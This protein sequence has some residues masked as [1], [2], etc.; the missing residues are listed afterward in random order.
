[1]RIQQLAPRTSSGNVQAQTANYAFDNMSFIRTND[2]NYLHMSCAHTLSAWE[3]TKPA[4]CASEGVVTRYCTTCAVYDEGGNRTG[5]YSETEYLPALGH[6]LATNWT[7]VEDT[8][9]EQRVCTRGGCDYAVT[10]DVLTDGAVRFDDGTLVSNS[11]VSI[12]GLKTKDEGG[13]EVDVPVGATDSVVGNDFVQYAIVDAPGREGELALKV[14]AVVANKKTPYNSS[15]FVVSTTDGERGNKYTLDFDLYAITRDATN[16]GRTFFHLTIG[17]QNYQVVMYKSAGIVEIRIY[18]SKLDGTSGSVTYVLGK[19]SNWGHARLEYT[20]GDDGKGDIYFMGKD[21]NGEYTVQKAVT[22][23]VTFG[24]G[25]Q[26]VSFDFNGTY[27]DA[28]CYFDNITFVRSEV[29]EPAE[30]V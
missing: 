8:N 12:T 10:R 29:I 4:E 16:S 1:M 25:E 9:T 3:I 27:S 14:S 5:G 28:V 6:D 22:R 30:E 21:A 13:A 11:S 7:V 2:T 15:K 19:D 18:G 20:I 17:N 26:T 24:T 23:N